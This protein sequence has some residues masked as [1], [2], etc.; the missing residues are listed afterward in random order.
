[1]AL[2]QKL[3]LGFA[4]LIRRCG[5]NKCMAIVVTMSAAAIVTADGACA[6]VDGDVD[7]ADAAD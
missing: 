5:A 3:L 7:A 6:A 4:P 1:M 2:Q